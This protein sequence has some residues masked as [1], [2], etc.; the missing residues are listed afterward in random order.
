[1]THTHTARSM[2]AVTSIVF[3]SLSLAQANDISLGEPIALKLKDAQS[4]PPATQPMQSAAGQATVAAIE[5]SAKT[6]ARAIENLSI[7]SGDRLMPTLKKWL[8]DQNVEL[9][10][11]AN[12]A[13][14]GRVR[15]VVF[16]DDFESSS[17]D[18]N[19]ALTESLSP[20]GFEAE[21]SG[22]ASVRRVTVRNLRSNL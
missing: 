2:V 4:I 5:S 20:F 13:T 1:M 7:R 3:A 8:A 10:W 15:D 21:I 17:A 18:L 14:A 22:G 6:S 9:V 19:V 12:A 11:A 16:E